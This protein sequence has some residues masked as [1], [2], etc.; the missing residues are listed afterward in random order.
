MIYL[1]SAAP[2]FAT[3]E[4]SKT[5]IMGCTIENARVDI[6]TSYVES[7]MMGYDLAEV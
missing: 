7:L 6:S 1:K 5:S 3:I 2:V 4:S